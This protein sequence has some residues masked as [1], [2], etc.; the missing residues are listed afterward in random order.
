MYIASIG[1]DLSK[2]SFHLLALGECNKILVR[3]EF[4]FRPLLGLGTNFSMV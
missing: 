3:K 2:T 4:W 1:I